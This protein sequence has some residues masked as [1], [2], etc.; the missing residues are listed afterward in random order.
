VYAS[1]SSSNPNRVV[2]V[3]INKKS[4]IVVTAG[5]RLAHPSNLGSAKVYVLAGT[6][7]D[8]VAA[9]AIPATD[10]N[11]FSYA[12]PPRSVSV[13]VFEGEGAVLPI[14]GGVAL[15]GAAGSPL[16]APAVLD[17]AASDLGSV[18]GQL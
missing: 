12:M 8:I 10:I 14:D 1:L 4:D 5:I 6:K 15:D 9:P 3:A 13:L 17:A 11:A 18:D 16:D 2:V 7:P